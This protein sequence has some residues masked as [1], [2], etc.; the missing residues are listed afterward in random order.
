M[1]GVVSCVKNEEIT[2]KV[3]TDMNNS[4]LMRAS[5]AGAVIGTM[6]V[7]FDMMQICCPFTGLGLIGFIVP[8]VL[9]WYYARNYSLSC[10]SAGCSY[11][12][13]LGFIAVSMI[14]A[15]VLYGA[16]KAVA[17][18]TF[19]EEQYKALLGQSMDMIKQM[20]IYS[21]AQIKQ[22]NGMMNTMQFNPIFIVFTSIFS[23]VFS[24][25]LYGLVIAAFTRREADP[26]A[27]HNQT[28]EN[29][30]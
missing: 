18:N 14:F 2:K 28:N 4:Y 25:V 17:V 6:S 27:D 29:E 7:V 23:M 5:I 16:L 26:F 20:G 3:Q 10:G 11:G 12:Q 9:I 24:G 21:K 15:G 19:V 22:M 8:V 30:Q 13:V 1:R